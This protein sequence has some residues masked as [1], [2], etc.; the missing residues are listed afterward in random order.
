MRLLTIPPPKFMDMGTQTII[1]Y[2][3]DYPQ[4]GAKQDEEEEVNGE[5]LEDT[6][7]V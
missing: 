4:N 2:D 5:D 3:S 6:I 7:P 1:E